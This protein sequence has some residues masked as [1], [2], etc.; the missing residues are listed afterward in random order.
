MTPL[1]LLQQ[2]S[3]SLIFKQLAGEEEDSLA[4]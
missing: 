1:L 3:H 2:M 4:D